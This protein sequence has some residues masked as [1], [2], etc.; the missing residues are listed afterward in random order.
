MAELQQTLRDLLER[1]EKEGVDWPSDLGLAYTL[2]VSSCRSG[3]TITIEPHLTT[4]AARRARQLPYDNHGGKYWV[5]D[6][7]YYVAP[8]EP[9][10]THEESVTGRE[11]QE[12]SESE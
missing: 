12:V 3:S 10:E 2:H 8:G 7:S 11:E 1:M 5:K 9:W 4:A 6:R